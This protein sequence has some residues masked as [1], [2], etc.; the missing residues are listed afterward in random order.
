MLRLPD[1]EVDGVANLF[2]VRMSLNKFAAF[3][4]VESFFC[5]RFVVEDSYNHE[6]CFFVAELHRVACFEGFLKH[7]H[8]LSQ[9][10]VFLFSF[11]EG[12]SLVGVSLD[13]VELR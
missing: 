5:S 3:D 10:V 7:R 1:P 11:L 13:P 6:G 8:S 12:F 2:P 4:L 9:L